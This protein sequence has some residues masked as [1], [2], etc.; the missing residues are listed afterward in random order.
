M[1]KEYRTIQE[2]AGQLMLISQIGGV[3]CDELGEIELPGGEIRRC[4]VLEVDGS[5]VIVQL[6]ESS[7][8]INIAY[9]K[10]RF[11]GRGFELN[12]SSDMLGR[13]FS[14]FGEPI[15]NGAKIIPET[16]LDVNGSLMNPVARNYSSELIQTGVSAIDGLNPLIRGQTL[17]IFSNQEDSHLN[18]AVQIARQ[19]KIRSAESNFAVVF[20]AVGA[21]FEEADCFLSEFCN[22]GAISRTAMFIS[23]ASS[24]A[25]ERLLT[26]RVALTAAEFLAYEKNMH[27]L[28]IITDMFNYAE[29][30]R[31]VSDARRE[32]T[33]RGGYPSYFCS[34]LASIYERAG[35]QLESEGS[36][37]LMPMLPIPKNY[38][39][40]LILDYTRHITDGQ[41]VLSQMMPR[42][43]CMS[44]VDALQ[45]LSRLKDRAVNGENTREDYSD[46]MNQLLYCYAR[47]IEVREQNAVSR[48]AP[49]SAA[50]SLYAQFADAFEMRYI[51]QSFDEERTLEQTLDLGWELLSIFPK[52]ELKLIKPELFIEHWK[53][54]R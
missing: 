49:Q 10:A 23:L 4:K 33:G 52:S 45:S 39:N 25:I 37:T 46:I 51:N 19:A 22:T 34:D 15:D 28:V 41:I 24:P 40:H 5:N 53:G 11:L 32:I 21:T 48:E 31:E 8:G 44:S 1:I 9:D 16:S 27:V 35:E 18:L 36:I 12:V 47:G 29:A 17:P 3:K 38:K 6:F 42:N 7:D 30:L 13:V 20:A 43:N 50:N 14:G 26:P 2:V 54:E